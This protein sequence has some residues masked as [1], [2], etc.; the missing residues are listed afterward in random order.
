MFFSD[1]SIQAQNSGPLW[2]DAHGRDKPQCMAERAS[3][4][5]Q[6]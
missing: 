2:L 1:E 6:T 4:G 3:S 5:D